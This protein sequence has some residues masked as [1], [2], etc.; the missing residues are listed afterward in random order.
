[1]KKSRSIIRDTL[2][3]GDVDFKLSDIE[4]DEQGDHPGK[5]VA[6]GNHADRH[7]KALTLI[8]KRKRGDLGGF[9]GFICA[10]CARLRGVDIMNAAM[11]HLGYKPMDGV[12]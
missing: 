9:V 12:H 6:C 5:C 3:R 10:E 1:M 8:P 7:I 2:N 4:K 11:I